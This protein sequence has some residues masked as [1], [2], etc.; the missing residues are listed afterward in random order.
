M[1]KRNEPVRKRTTDV[2]ADLLAGHDR[3]AMDGPQAARKYLER[4]LAGQQSLANAVK[5]FAYDLLSDAALKCEE[6]ERA[7]EAVEAARRYLPAAQ[8]ESP[9][10]VRSW[11]AKARYFDV[12]ITLAVDD[13]EFEAALALCEEAI[14]LG[15]GSVYER[16]ADSIRRMV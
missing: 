15:L 6:R 2:L 12:G 3:A 11:L 16:K 9:R 1:S 14:G 8:E 10:E 4:V 13:G 5:F 7:A